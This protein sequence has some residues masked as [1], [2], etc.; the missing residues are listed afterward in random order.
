MRFIFEEKN[1]PKFNRKEYARK[2]TGI[3]DSLSSN[4]LKQNEALFDLNE[5]MNKKRV[6]DKKKTVKSINIP[7]K[8]NKD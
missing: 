4:H 1:K 7:K 8:F 3:L 2:A 5:D 6:F